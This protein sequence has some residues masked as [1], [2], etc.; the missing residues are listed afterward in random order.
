MAFNVV[1]GGLDFALPPVR[2]VRQRFRIVRE[3]AVRDAVARELPKLEGRIRP[4]M[5]VA[6]GVGSRGVARIAEVA[7]AVVDALKARGAQPFIVPA[8]GSHGGGTPQG[9]LEVLEGYGVTPGSMGVPIDAS[10]E[11]VQIGTTPGGFPVYLARSAAQ[12]DA[13]LPINRVKVHTDFH[14]PVESGLA[15]MLVIGFGKQTGAYAIHK[16]GFDVFHELIPAAATVHL[17]RGKVLGGIATVE[18]AEEDIAHLEAV[19]ADQI[20]TREPE[21]LR[22]SRELMAKIPFDRIDVLV[23][24][25]I[26]KNISG[27]GM[28]PNVTGRYTVRH[29]TDPRNPKKLVVLRLTELTHGNACGLGL[30]DVTTKAVLDNVDFQKYWTN[31]ITS[32]ELGGGKTP[33]W[34]LNDRQAIALAVATANRVEAATARLVRIPSTMHLEELT[35]SEALWQADGTAN[36]ALESLSGPEPMRFT[37]EGRLEDLP[38]PAFRHGLSAWAG[39]AR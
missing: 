5:R 25:Y 23:I 39:V 38:M 12:A 13:V 34:M 18:H 29:I 21:L 16:R 15:K 17:D 37:A 2:R 26:G 31:I 10:M 6:V 9:Q 24:D 27:S 4:G 28:D 1:E 22:T 8:M 35:V 33:I 11:T 3:V 36:P 20:L 14:G 7:R 30:A 19:P 32:T